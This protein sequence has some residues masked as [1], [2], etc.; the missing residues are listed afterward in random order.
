M[1]SIRLTAQRHYAF[2]M[3]GTE[4]QL[5]IINS[6]WQMNHIAIMAMI[7]KFQSDNEL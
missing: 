3:T 5:L 1:E 4:G 7:T 2:I 6:V